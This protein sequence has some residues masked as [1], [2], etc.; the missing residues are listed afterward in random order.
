MQKI[1]N[2]TFLSY[3]LIVILVLI[4]LVLGYF[5]SVAY[6]NKRIDERIDEEKAA[7]YNQGRTDLMLEI[8]NEGIIASYNQG[9]I[10]M[11]QMIRDTFD[12]KDEL[13]LEFANDEKI[14]LIKKE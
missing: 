2:R 13:I 7:S 4:I 14:I 11:M 12:T 9:R 10:N 5:Q 8:E 6:L 1:F 3:V